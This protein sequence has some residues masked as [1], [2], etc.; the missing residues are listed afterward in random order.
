MARN[1]LHEFTSDLR[2][3]LCPKGCTQKAPWALLPDRRTNT[4]CNKGSTRSSQSHPKKAQAN[5]DVSLTWRAGSVELTAIGPNVTK[6]ALIATDIGKSRSMYPPLWLTPS[7]RW[8]DCSPIF[9]K[10][11]SGSAKLARFR[12]FVRLWPRGPTTFAAQAAGTGT[13]LANFGLQ[14][15]SCASYR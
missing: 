14:D 13:I 4:K 10:L 8:P 9:A 12:Q 11:N 2:I 5:P 6:L 3:F 7:R 15:W 1:K